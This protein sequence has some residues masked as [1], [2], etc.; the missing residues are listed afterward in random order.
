M[1]NKTILGSLFI[2]ASTLFLSACGGSGSSDPGLGSPIVF[3]EI[4]PANTGQFSPEFFELEKALWSKDVEKGIELQ[5]D[6]HYRI[7]NSLP[8][9]VTLN[10]ETQGLNQATLSLQ[11]QPRNHHVSQSM[12]T[13]IEFLEAALRLPNNGAAQKAV[14]VY[15]LEIK[16]GE[17]YKLSGSVV[18]FNYIS[19]IDSRNQIELVETTS[20]QRVT[21]KA[22][23][24]Q[25]AFD[26]EL[27]YLEPHA[28]QIAQHPKGYCCNLDK[29]H[30][31]LGEQDIANISVVCVP[32][33]QTSTVDVSE[34]IASFD[35]DSVTQN[36]NFDQLH[37]KVHTNQYGDAVLQ[38]DAGLAGSSHKT[39]FLSVH[40]ENTQQWQHPA[41][42]AKQDPLAIFGNTEHSF[43]P[44]Q[45]ALKLN[46]QK[47]LNIAFAASSA[48]SVS[49]ANLYSWSGHLQAITDGVTQNDELDSMVYT[50]NSQENDRWSITLL[51]QGH[52]R[53]AQVRIV[54]TASQYQLQYIL[55]ENYNTQQ[56]KYLNETIQII[57]TISA[58]HYSNNETP[59]V[60]AVLD[61]SGH[62]LVVWSENE[63]SIQTN[64]YSVEIQDFEIDT[65][66]SALQLNHERLDPQTPQLHTNEQGDWLLVWS[67]SQNGAHVI[68]RKEKN[69][70]FAVWSQNQIDANT[71]YVDT[72]SNHARYAFHSVLAPS[73]SHYAIA[74]IEH[75]APS[76]DQ[77]KVYTVQN[78]T[79]NQSAQ[80]SERVVEIEE[81]FPADFDVDPTD[82]SPGQQNTYKTIHPEGVSLSMG[83]KF[84]LA[85]AFQA[86]SASSVITVQKTIS[87]HGQNNQNILKLLSVRQKEDDFEPAIKISLNPFDQE[88]IAWQQPTAADSDETEVVMATTFNDDIPFDAPAIS[89]SQ[90]GNVKLLDASNA[91]RCG[92]FTSLI[93]V[94]SPLGYG[95]MQS[96]HR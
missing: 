61:A 21:I 11:G 91:S 49:G 58:Q 68:R 43:F 4:H 94:D 15:P 70:D 55:R 26:K 5:E 40:H 62:G 20:N 36:I 32:T 30:G 92:G 41:Q 65:A 64:L 57:G 44:S 3:Q 81:V 33:G 52:V 39:G 27:E 14:R 89:L 84:T 75:I 28:I 79:V 76:R 9:G 37:G 95:I 69:A 35:L 22:G 59:Y 82:M 54:K 67:E 24:T 13:T 7:K 38:W 87:N 63:N 53:A 23:Q 85:I 50:Q 93:K 96:S 48:P 77:L 47:S 12:T 10:I 78:S 45:S 90:P 74:Y 6:L 34:N 1:N 29:G 51:S 42:A 83:S 88:T 16:F 8:E 60:D 86:Q 17:G 46:E 19:N 25:F 72:V 80:A 66:A 73:A 18:P 2:L 31:I 56:N 71:T